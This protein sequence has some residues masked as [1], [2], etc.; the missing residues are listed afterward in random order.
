MNR[1]PGGKQPKMHAT[2]NPATGERQ[3][4]VFELSD[5]AVDSEG[6][7]LV[8]QA[9]GMEQVLRERGL[10]DM[11]DAA[12]D[13]QKSGS[14]AVGVCGECAKSQKARDLEAK[15]RHEGLDPEDAAGEGAFDDDD[16]ERPVDCCMQR[17]L[18]CQPDFKAEKPLL[19]VL[20][21]KRGHICLFLPKFHCELNPIEMV[22]AQIKRR[23]SSLEFLVL[24]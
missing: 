11:L 14:K 9:K 13:K 3:S 7:S 22:W 2:I 15:A 5:D 10:L 20:I 12:A 6:K 18:E 4:M 8:G 24:L 23:K 1:S 17:A 21:E 16:D 19:Q